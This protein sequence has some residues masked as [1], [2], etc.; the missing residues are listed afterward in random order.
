MSIITSLSLF[1]NNFHNKK[2]TT[3]HN[4]LIINSLLIK[5]DSQYPLA[6]LFHFLKSFRNKFNYF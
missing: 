5:N 6:S 4:R 2:A 1:Y 3:T